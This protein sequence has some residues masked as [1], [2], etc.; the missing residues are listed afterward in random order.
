MI[1]IERFTEQAQEALRRA[2]E[3]LLRLGQRELD[4]THLLFALL[5][6][7]NGQVSAVC[8]KLGVEAKAL[9]ARVRGLLGSRTSVTGSALYITPRAN[10]V[11]DRAVADADQR[12][13]AYVSVEHLF[14]SLLNESDGPTAPLLREAGLAP[15]A[16][17][18]AF[19][20]LRHNAPVN[21]PRAEQRAG[22]LDRYS[23]DLTAL[24]RTDQLD[25]VIGRESE[26]L[27]LMEVLVRR[28]KNNPVLIGEPGVGKTAIVEGL[29]RRI[30]AGDVPEPL[31]GKRVLALDL[32]GMVAG[33]KFRGEFEERLKSV[34]DEIQAAKGEII[35]FIDELHLLVGA[36]AA[37][38]A[39][40]AANLMKPLLARGALRCIGATTLDEYRERIE[41]DAALERRFQPIYVDEPSV[42]DTLLILEGLRERYETHHGLRIEAEALAAAAR[43]GDRYLRD[44]HLPDKAIDLMDEACS[45]V[46]LRDFG[47]PP[48]VRALRERVTALQR[49]EDEA[50]QGRDYESAARARAERLQLEPQLPAPSSDAP[51]VTVEDVAAVVAGW[52]GIPVTQIHTQDLQKLLHLEEHLHQRVVGQH[53]A[54]VAVADALR[55]SR[56]GIADPRRP[57]GSFLFLGPTGVGKTELARALAEFLFDDERALLRIDMSEYREPHTVSRLYGAPPGYV[58]YDQAGQLTEA[59]RR[60]PYQVV[61]FDEIEKA[62]PDVLNALLQVL[63]DGRMTDGQGRT[64]DFQ[65]TVIIMTSNAGSRQMASK[66]RG[67]LGFQTGPASAVDGDRRLMRERVLEAVKD[68]FR[69]EFLNRIDEVIVFD[70]LAPE[71]LRQI[72]DKMLRDVRA[73]LAARQIELTLADSA[74]D[75]LIEHGYDEAYGA[76]SLRRLVQREIENVLARRVLAAEV[77]SGDRVV[78]GAGAEGLT[79]EVVQPMVPATVTTAA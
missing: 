37:E 31:R 61:L 69:P 24:A 56:S 1:P 67:T 15:A 19:A 9:A 12:G 29:A 74:A 38:G 45:K 25:P 62:H 23:I 55:R 36:G 3:L 26:I 44:R 50:W 70:R 77:G 52:T 73:R 78:V 79:F 76:R 7:P 28:T 75:W 2:Q 32:G 51:R 16:V 57:L 48:E 42:D 58:G 54:V 64:V 53:E 35:C 27:R 34:L 49:Q 5:E 6:Q 66:S 17:A 39:M 72:V 21:D 71:Q 4:T 46:R 14:L 22:A 33:S 10:R 59:V 41:K 47:G 60:R 20:E 8:A 11:I 63:D 13:D 43:L 68:A 40:D 30:T 18:E 65:N